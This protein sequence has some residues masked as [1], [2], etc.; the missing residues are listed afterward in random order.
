VIADRGF[1]PAIAG[2]LLAVAASLFF[3][4]TPVYSSSGS[5]SVPSRATD[6]PGAGTA[7]APT[8]S[9]TLLE[10][11]GSSAAAV[12]AVPVGLAL[13]AVVV[14]RARVRGG[15]RATVAVLLG[16]GCM[17][18]AMSVGLLY[19]PAAAALAVSAAVSNARGPAGRR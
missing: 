17:L 19:V 3:V 9:T 18:G 12:L 2:L 6:T 16:I 7:A 5:T 10:E 8:E 4:L 1:V 15:V 13:V 11:N 14:T